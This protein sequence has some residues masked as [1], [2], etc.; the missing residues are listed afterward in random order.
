MV[1]VR[2]DPQVV[3]PNDVETLRDLVVGALQDAAQNMRETVKAILGPVAAAS[4]RPL[5]ESLSGT[6]MFEGPVQDLI[7][8]LGKL[9]G[10]GPK[11]R[12]GSP[13][14]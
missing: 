8:E 1:S 14:T 10:I 2:I 5:P 9:P 7:D 13:S 12:S 3:D 11:A 6:A 4:G